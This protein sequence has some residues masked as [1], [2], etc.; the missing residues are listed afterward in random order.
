MDANIDE[1]APVGIIESAILNQSPTP[2]TFSKINQT[3][4]NNIIY[5]QKKIEE[6]GNAIKELKNENKQLKYQL[7][8]AFQNIISIYNK[9]NM[10][11][12]LDNCLDKI[13]HVDLN[14]QYNKLDNNLYKLED[15][16]KSLNHE[17]I[18]NRCEFS[19]INSGVKHLFNKNIKKC[20]LKYKATVDGKNVETFHSKCDEI[21]YKLFIIRTTNERR[22][23]VFFSGKPT[24]NLDSFS[25]I[26]RISSFKSFDSILPTNF[27]RTFNSFDN[28]I[29]ENYS[30][31]YMNNNNKNSYNNRNDNQDEIFNCKMCPQKFFIFS[32][33][34]GKIYYPLP[35]SGNFSKMPCFSINFDPET[36]SYY[37]KE[38]KININIQ[39][40]ECVLSGKEEFN[41]LEFEVYE[42]EIEQ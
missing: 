40:K 38:N 42:I 10:F 23:G 21:F 20:I 30:I 22:F 34:K 41:I 17:I 4:S 6:Q 25:K 11:N 8:E 14:F 27:Y 28:Y 32:L 13:N 12:K 36:E 35:N 26:S 3:E 9:L 33:N 2:E 1:V 16:F 5:L 15:S 37:G 39:T 29:S 19:T 18:K 7:N 31:D 24:K